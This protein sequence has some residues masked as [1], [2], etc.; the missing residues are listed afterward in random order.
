MGL[1]DAIVGQGEAAIADYVRRYELGPEQ[2][3]DDEARRNYDTVAEQLGSEQYVDAAKEALSRFSPEQRLQLVEL[4]RGEARRQD[5]SF[6]ELHE[7]ARLH[8]PQSLAGFF[9]HM[10]RNRPGVLPQLLGSHPLAKAALAG[11]AAYG[12]KRLSGR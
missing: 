2:I 7:D 10:E 5:F 12:M 3:T 4:M 6:P 1:L 9:A 8:E 11:I